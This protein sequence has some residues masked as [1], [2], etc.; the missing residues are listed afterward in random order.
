[1]ENPKTLETLGTQDTGRKIKTQRILQQRVSCYARVGI[2]LTYCKYWHVHI[3]SITGWF[4]HTNLI[5]PCHIFFIEV[6]VLIQ[7]SEWSCMCV[8]GMGFA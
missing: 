2:L 7:G 4:G 5:L 1:M 6:T 8:F 3:I